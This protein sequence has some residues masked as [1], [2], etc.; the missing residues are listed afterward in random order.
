MKKYIILLLT[1]FMVLSINI[2]KAKGDSIPPR[3]IGMKMAYRSLNGKGVELDYKKAYK[4]FRIYAKQGDGEALNALG[5]M[6]KRGIG[7][8]QNDKSAF[9]FFQRAMK[10][11]YAK[12]AFNLGLMYKFGNYVAQNQDSAFYWLNKSKEMGFDRTNYMFGHAFYKGQGTKQDYTEAVKCY[13][14][15]SQKGDASCMFMLGYCYFRGRGVERNPE[16]GKY[17]IEKSADKGY[18]RAIDFIARNNSK[19]FGAEKKQ[20]KNAIIEPINGFIPVKHKVVKNA[21]SNTSITGEWEGK[22]IT[23]DWSGEEIEE[24]VPVKVVLQTT[25]ESIDGLWIENGTDPIRIDAVLQ[26]TSWIFNNIQ[27]HE[28]ERPM[29]METG[30]F[31]IETNGGKE[32][33]T[34]N[35]IFYSPVTKEYFLPNNIVL[36]RKST[37]TETLINNEANEFIVYPNPFEGQFTLK[38]SLDR[39]QKVSVM[40]FDMQSRLI[41]SEKPKDYTQGNHT[42]DIITSSF[43]SGNYVIKLVGESINKSAKIIKQ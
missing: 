21:V 8:E 11:G 20:L 3:D 14:S 16:L 37:T 41:Y 38:F 25:G 1:I 33:L 28:N 4:I 43:A 18:T 29:L 24:E 6:Y 39:T 2:A 31:S 30:R 10:K 27:L 13:T 9:G 23:Y 17:W 7:P 15:G 19:T 5:M 12:G 26:D 36:E 42:K 40:I 22:L 32:Y 34:G 35:V